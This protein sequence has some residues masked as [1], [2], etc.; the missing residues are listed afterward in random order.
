MKRLFAVV[1]TLMLMLCAPLALAEEANF[2][3]VSYDMNGASYTIDA[4]AK[5]PGEDLI[6]SSSAPTWR[7]HVFLGWALSPDAKEAKYQ[8]EDTFTTD[9]DTTLYAVWMDC[10]DLGTVSGDGVYTVSYPVT[11]RFA[12]VTFT[13]EKSGN[14]VIRSL[15]QYYKGSAG[16]TRLE[17]LH[18]YSSYTD[19]KT[20]HIDWN[21][22]GFEHLTTLEA[23]KTYYLFYYQSKETLRLQISDAVYTVSYDTNGADYGIDA[24]PKYAGEDLILSSSAPTWRGH[25]FLGW[26]LSPDAKEAKYQPED[27]FTTDAD[28]TLYA[29]WMDCADLGTVSGDGVYTVSYPVT[30]R[31]AYVT[32]TPEKSGNYVIRSLDQYYKGSAGST[33]L[34]YLHQYSSY[35][36]WKTEHIDWNSEGFEHLTTLEAG[37]TYYLFYYQSKETLKLQITYQY[38]GAN[39][40]PDAVIPAAL[41]V[42]PEEAFAGAAFGAV[43]IPETVASVSSQAFADCDSLTE[44]LVRSADTT[45]AE[46]A[47]SGCGNLLV[48]A[49]LDSGAQALAEANGWEF[50]ELEEELMN[51]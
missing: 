18:Q 22:E 10:A 9:A 15:D 21:S 38:A 6:L 41:T 17:Y 31:F 42:I 36:D 27:T 49:P 35:T 37:K 5:Y 32:F 25:V 12:Y 46:D 24:Q 30:K 45:F 11:K 29:V 28:T 39:F 19:W 34:E 4:Q 47:F 13:P 51:D 1:L 14:Y 2:Y 48:I 7:G 43:E 40:K 33:R 20:E 3:V 8:P 50:C 26:A 16:S 44:L 23:G